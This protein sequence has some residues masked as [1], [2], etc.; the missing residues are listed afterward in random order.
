MQHSISLNED[1]AGA[2]FSARFS[3]Y[4]ISMR[5]I[6]EA[7]AVGI[8]IGLLTFIASDYLP[9]NLKFLV[10]TK[11][12]WAL[13]PFIMAF[14]LP[15]RRRQTDAITVSIITLLTTGLTYY[16]TEVI[17]LHNAF[18]FPESAAKF[19]FT[20]IV[21]GAAIGTLAYLGRSATNQFIRYGSMSLLPAVYTGDGINEIIKSFNNFEFTPEIGV[22]VIGGILFYIAIAGHNKFKTK[23]LTSFLVLAAIATLAYL[24][25]I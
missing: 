7:V 12:I 5:K 4:N 10:E 6:I 15:I 16:L 9:D 25:V 24:Y 2:N 20:A 3:C 14:N 1:K 22:K 13:P 23:A 8:L 18:Y 21:G 19:I 11:L 17:K